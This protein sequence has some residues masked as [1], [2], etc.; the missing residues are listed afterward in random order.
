MTEYRTYKLGELLTKVGSGVTPKGGSDVY[1]D[2]GVP[3]IRSQNVLWGSLSTDGIAYIEP[4]Q[5]AKM[6][7]SS[8][9]Q[10]DVLLN[11]T[12]ASIGRA[13]VAKNLIGEANVNQHVCILRPSERIDPS[14]LMN[15]L[16][17]YYGQK[18]ITLFQAGG[19]R[20]GLNYEQVRSFE[21]PLPPLAEQQKIAEILRT[22]DEA[23]EVAEADLK[24]KQERKR[25]LMQELLVGD[26][27]EVTIGQLFELEGSGIDKIVVEGEKVVPL[28]NYMDAYRNRIITSDLVN[29]VTSVNE[30]DLERCRLK[31]GDIVVTP[32]SETPDDIAH[33][34]LI[35]YEPGDAVHSYHLFRL[36]P[37]DSSQFSDR[38]GAFFLNH[39]SVRKQFIRIC[40]GTTRY[41]LTLPSVRKIKVKLPPVSHQKRAAEA[42]NCATEQESSVSLQIEALR[43][44][45][46]GLMQKLLTGEVRVAA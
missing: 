15:F 29:A 45:K 12:G 34:A 1:V 30:R 20:Q 19:N 28:V 5:H 44:Q 38:F 8:V 10:G 21:I 33:S 26:W 46:R 43:T 37:K 24:A 13:C 17:S 31:K 39:E 27:P 9:R 23:I 22:W 42:L 16:I 40:S 6:S 11:I 18:Q 2:S 14:Y 3:L 4:A 32:S 41:T 35:D 36:R 7:S 25:W